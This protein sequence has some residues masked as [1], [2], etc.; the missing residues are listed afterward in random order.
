M[1]KETINLNIIISLIIF[2]IISILTIYTTIPF[3]KQSLHNL[4]LKQLLFYLV[5]FI[6]TIFITY[7]GFSLLK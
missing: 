1:K 5:G 7:I 2:A 6:I 3:L 4:Y